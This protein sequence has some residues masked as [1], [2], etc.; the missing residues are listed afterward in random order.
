MFL[1]SATKATLEHARKAK[2]A[3]S[4]P[5]GVNNEEPSAKD[6]DNNE[7]ESTTY[8]KSPRNDQDSIE[9]VTKESNKDKSAGAENISFKDGSSNSDEDTTNTSTNTSSTEIDSRARNS[10]NS[11][12]SKQNHDK[13]INNPYL[14][15]K[16]NVQQGILHAHQQR[17]A[18]NVPKTPSGSVDKQIILK[19]GMLRSHIHR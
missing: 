16:N 8:D 12:N 10:Y 3:L 6:N 5:S 13:Q 14:K 2:E 1:S 9:M 19:K 4:T 7:E 11:D 18:N 15:M 17:L